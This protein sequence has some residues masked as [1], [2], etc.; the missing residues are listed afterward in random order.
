MKGNKQVKNIKPV[1]KTEISVEEM[2]TSLTQ[3]VHS[4]HSLTR[5]MCFTQPQRLV[6]F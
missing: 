6:S 5:Q 2:S 4:V 3:V 1:L